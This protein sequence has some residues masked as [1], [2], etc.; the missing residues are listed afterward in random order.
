MKQSN[1]I[2]PPK[3]PL[4]LLR[5]FLKKEYL[6]EIEGDLEELFRDNIDHG[7]SSRQAG[8]MY[9]WEMVRLLRPVLM[10][11]LRA[12]HAINQY[13]MF[14]NYF[15]TS[16]RSLM[17]N[18]LSS[19]INV[20][21]LA[22]ATGICL[23][24]YTFMEYDRSIDQFHKNKNEIYLVTFFA[25]SDS[26]IQQYGTTP[27]PLGD[28]L[29]QDFAQ[30][31]KVCRVED[32]NVVLKYKDNVF[33]ERV[34]YADAAFLELFTFPLKW[35]T[36]NSLSDLNSIVLSEEMSIKYFGNENPVGQDMLMVFSDTIKKVF[37][38]TGV[39]AAFPKSRDIDFNFLVNFENVRVSEPGYDR[40]DW[41]KFLNATLVQIDDGTDV[42]S[43]EQKMEKYRAMQNEAQ[44]DW[45]ISSFAFEPLV[46]LHEKAANIKDGIAHDGNVEGRIGM[47]IIAILMI[48]LA[49]FN[50]INIAIVSAAKR[51]KEIG[52]RK[53]IGASRSKVIVQFLTENIVV[54]FFALTIGLALCLFV[55]LPWFVQFSGWPLELS[56]LNE[57]LWMFLLVLLLFTGIASGIY[58]AFYVSG[59]DTIKIFKGSLQFGKKNPLTKIFL[60]IQLVL[61]C[62]TITAGV[63]FT[64]NNTFQG[65][66]SWGYDQKDALYVS[67]PDKPAFDR[68]NAVMMQNPNVVS[69]S[70]SSDHLGRTVSTEML[71]TSSNQ[72]Y[73]VNRFSVDAD[74]M[75]T[76]GL[77]LIE[78]RWFRKDS[79]TDKQ[80]LIVNELFAKNL[81]LKQPVGQLFEID[82][83]KYEVIGVLKDF[84]TKD[85]FSKIQP[86]I[87]KLA[88]EQDYRYLAIRVKAG[89]AKET[90]KAMQDQWMKFY[91]EVP[92]Q[93]GYQEDVW[94][95]YFHSVDRSEKFNK[96]IASIAVLLASLGLYGL[97]TLN[98][99][100]RTKEFSIR[101]TLGAGV[102]SIASL[103][104]G[105]YAILTLVSLIIGA[106]VS[107]VLTKAYL[108]MLFAYPMPMGYSGIAIALV[109]LTFILLAVISTQINKVSKLNPVDGLKVE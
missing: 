85:F 24:V 30:I 11:N 29:K 62:I 53:V 91:P 94:T 87:F 42:R 52:V 105:Q 36:A 37:T 54:T 109:I 38:V 56:L 28:V 71:H 61:A 101:K 27:R 67:V 63:V 96:V 26:V 48:V 31:R 25:G 57:N 22:V 43:I 33:H 6:E 74:Y 70:G 58:P 41:S 15:K 32:R 60:G 47:P 44:P 104:V 16:F 108:D 51:L 83:M 102:T 3:W 59:F 92:Y 19:F 106:P 7:H 86:A 1:S 88:E 89:T 103:L 45:A 40:N 72:Q 68:M 20:F 98:V 69:L 99:S 49:C 5:L 97:V 8:R 55:F 65:S 64:Q 35:G 76:M 90:H 9:T 10:K 81:N 75:K 80:A 2:S 73:E 77:K 17:K 66:Q 82:S 50:Y 79:R 23:V 95:S 107:Y 39:A 78:G 13:P 84:H 21:G 93:G 100:G 14:K 34:R 12:V 46:T 4:K 18:P